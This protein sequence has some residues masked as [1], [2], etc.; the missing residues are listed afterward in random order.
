MRDL[1]FEPAFPAVT[2]IL[3]KP[4]GATAAALLAR[5][6]PDGVTALIEGCRSNDSTVRKNAA[7][8]LQSVRDSRAVEALL[9]L[10]RD[11]TPVVRLH[12][13]RAAGLNW[14]RRFVEPMIGLFYDANPEIRGEATWTL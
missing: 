1:E 13:V 5:L 10:L 14:E 3:A 9:P 8:G 11:K 7:F 2:E 4:I 6:G 12:V